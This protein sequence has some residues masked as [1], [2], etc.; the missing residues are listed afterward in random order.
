MKL[1]TALI[2]VIV[3]AAIRVTFNVILKEDNNKEARAEMVSA[4]HTADTEPRGYTGW[5]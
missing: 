2:A 3:I 1:L 5:D 4:S